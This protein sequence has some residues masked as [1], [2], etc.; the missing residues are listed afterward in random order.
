MNEDA[1][2]NYEMTL[3]M[4]SMEFEKEQ[5]LIQDVSP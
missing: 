1:E 2:E 3:E 4:A 5:E